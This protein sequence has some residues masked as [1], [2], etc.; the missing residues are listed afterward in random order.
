[1]LPST[2][3]ICDSDNIEQK[4]RCVCGQ[5]FKSFLSTFPLETLE[6]WSFSKRYTFMLRITM[7]LTKGTIKVSWESKR[8]KRMVV[9]SSILVS[10]YFLKLH[11]PWQHQTHKEESRIRGKE[12]PRLNWPASVHYFAAFWRQFSEFHGYALLL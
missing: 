5:N 11:Q 12:R 9:W 3:N 10:Q 6:G 4:Y 7:C 1:M 8:E 2:F